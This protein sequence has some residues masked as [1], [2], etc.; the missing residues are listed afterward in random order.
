MAQPYLTL[1]QRLTWC[2]HFFKA[3]V[4]QHHRELRPLLSRSIGADAV[5]IDVGA[6]AGQFA[7]LFAGLA[8]RGHVYAFEP[9]AYA[10]S[11]LQPMLRLKGFG[12]VTVIAAG[13]SDQPGEATL[14]LPIKRSGSLGFGLGNLGRDD[15][16]RAQQRET[17]ATTTLDRFAAETGLQRMD[18]IKADIEGWEV[19]LLAGARESLARFHPAL[20]LE[21]TEHHLA[22]AGNRPEE[23]FAILL[24]LGYRAYRLPD[25]EHAVERFAGAGDYLF[26]AD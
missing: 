2:A 24:P 13:L 10:R 20:L 8:P 23:A 18:F 1:R 14:S 5:V 21:L 17:I 12:N 16:A 11:I 3:V 9:G 26:L 4:K 7:K 6:H 25:S 19:R 22:R 15:A